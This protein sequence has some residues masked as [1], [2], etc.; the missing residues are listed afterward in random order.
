MLKKCFLANLQGFELNHFHTLCNQFL[1]ELTL[2][3]FNILHTCYMHIEDVHE[4]V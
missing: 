4:E 2:D 1:S 3:L